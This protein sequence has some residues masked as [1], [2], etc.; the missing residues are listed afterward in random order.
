MVEAPSTTRTPIGLFR[1]GLTAPDRLE[2]TTIGR[3]EMLADLLEKLQRS[4]GKKTHQ[5]YVFIGPRG[6]G[7]THF[8]SLLVHRIES[9][10]DLC[11]RFTIVRFAEETH[12]LLSFADFL[13]RICEILTHTSED[14][15]WQELYAE[16][17]EEDDDQRIIDTLEPKLNRYRQDTGR[18]LLVLL[19]NLDEVLTRQ[20]KSKQDIH[21]LRKFLMTSPSCILVATA[22]LTFP[23]LTDVK[24]PFYDFFD[25]QTSGEPDAAADRRRDSR[26]PGIRPAS[27]LA[28]AV[29][30]AVAQDQGPARNDRRES[31]ARDHALCVDRR[32]ERPGGQTPVRGIARPDFPL[33]PGSHQGLAAAGTGGAGDHGADPLAA[34]DAGAAG[35]ET[36]QVAPADFVAAATA[37]EIRLPR[38]HGPSGRQ[39]VED[40]PHQGGLLRPVVE[41]ERIPQAAQT[42]AGADGVLRAVVS[43]GRTRAETPGAGGPAT[44]RQVCPSGGG[45]P[46]GD[47]GLPGRHR[48]RRREDRGENSGGGSPPRNRPSPGSRR[49][50]GRSQ[51]AEAAR[52]DAMADASWRAVGGQRSLAGSDQAGRGDDRLLG[53]AAGRA[54]GGIH[55]AAV[56]DRAIAAGTR[57]APG[58]GGS[59]PVVCSRIG[60]FRG[61]DPAYSP[62]GAKPANSGGSLQ[63][64][65][66][67]PGRPAVRRR[68]G[69]PQVG[70]RPR[71]T[72]SRRSTTRAGTTTGRWSIWSKPWRSVARSAI[73]RGKGPRSTTSRRSTTP[74]GTT[75]GRWSIWSKPWRSAARSAIGRG[76]GPRSTTSRRSTTPA[77]TTTGRWSIWSKPWRSVA[78]SATGRGK[79]PRSTTSRRS[80]T[81]AGTTTGR[82]SIWSKPWRSVARSATGRGRG[83]RSTTSRGSIDARGDYDRAL[84]Y[85]E[86]AVA[87]SREI[88]DRPGM[89]N[90]LF[91]IGHIQRT[92]QD[93]EA[94]MSSWLTAFQIAK[95]IGLAQGLE[96]LEALAKEMG[97]EDGLGFWESLSAKAGEPASG[98]GF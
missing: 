2:Q 93:T 50:S 42:P 13:L 86:Q 48:H 55:V 31:A 85:L 28:G 8:L 62:G 40:L 65:E 21:R 84:E 34:E 32:R 41:H 72:T 11:G 10:P 47:L 39:A 27:R 43:A 12:R 87:I 76:K 74:A 35:Q 75:T 52:R 36:P 83:P 92:K 46:R 7:K 51:D 30:R 78:R 95:E 91:N 67:T 15:A 70:R 61:Q 37:H 80:T 82:W 3:E 53:I 73:G 88:G 38:G 94:A 9:S 29:R 45:P 66:H 96:A 5:H 24:Q 16:L 81:R 90:T 98:A 33:L 1:A 71:S 79:G 69:K 23:G 14:A 89:C 56:E 68:R 54:L 22:P 25:I 59:V 26:E 60:G 58:A 97:H 18:I 64:P 57:T 49:V 6:I 20:I 19:E 44:R 77:G 4:T 63:C 17:A